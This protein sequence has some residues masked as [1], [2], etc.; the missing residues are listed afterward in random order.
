MVP[1]LIRLV[2]TKPHLLLNHAEAYAGLVAEE[3][4]EATGRWKQR[5]L[6]LGIALVAVIVALILGGVALM[7]WATLPM[8]NIHAPWAL[9][10][11]PLLPLAL[12]VCCLVAARGDGDANNF[13]NLRQQFKS[14]M[15]MLREVSSS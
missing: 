4:G 7:L 1:P 12:A 6:L 15:E 8:A 11:A 10:V 9:W 2:A 13:E 5:L 14:D 3:L